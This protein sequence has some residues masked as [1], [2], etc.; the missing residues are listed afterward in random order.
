MFDILNAALYY[1]PAD[2]AG[3][4]SYRRGNTSFMASSLERFLLYGKTKSSFEKQ[5]LC[6]NYP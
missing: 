3:A 5:A 6:A 1:S 4:I 2:S